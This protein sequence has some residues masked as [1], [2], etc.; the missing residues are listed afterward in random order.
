M[1][2]GYILGTVISFVVTIVPMIILSPR[3]GT[4]L[5]ATVAQ[6]HRSRGEITVTIN[7]REYEARINDSDIALKN[8]DDVPPERV[9]LVRRL[10]LEALKK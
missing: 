10:I 8:V 1:L 6:D 4:I 7:G 2:K 3:P 9:E 5:T